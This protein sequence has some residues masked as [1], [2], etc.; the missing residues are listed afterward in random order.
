[1][2]NDVM[3][4]NCDWII[5]LQAQLKEEAYE[6]T[7]RDIS[8]KLKT[9]VNEFTGKNIIYLQQQQLLLQYCFYYYC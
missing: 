7:I 2:A 4:V 9:V 6:E 3:T 8:D 5:P 1:M